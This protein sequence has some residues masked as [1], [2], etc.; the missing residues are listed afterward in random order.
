[1]LSEK[2]QLQYHIYTMTI[3]MYKGNACREKQKGSK[4]NKSSW[5]VKKMKLFIFKPLNNAI[6]I[7]PPPS[8]KEL[9]ELKAT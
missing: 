8:Q 1:M 7:I 6:I 3:I 9:L 5:Y 4:K 2:R